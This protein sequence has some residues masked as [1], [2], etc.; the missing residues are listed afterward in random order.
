MIRKL[1]ICLT[2]ILVVFIML[3]TTARAAEDDGPVW[4]NYQILYHMVADAAREAGMTEDCE[5]IQMCKKLW[6]EE[7]LKLNIVAKVIKYEAGNCPWL[8]RIAVGQVI[9]NRVRSEHFPNTVYDVVNQTSS[10]YDEEG[11]K[12]TIWQYNPAYCYNFEGIERQ[13]YED[14]KFVLDGNAAEWYV[15]IDV[16]WQAEFPQGKEIWWISTVDTE[17]FHSVTYFCR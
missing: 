11:V 4:T 15:P 12:H 8:H 10:W 5:L 13:F 2:V 7:Q 16:V 17:Y 6:W 3:G 14:A 1:L 9:L